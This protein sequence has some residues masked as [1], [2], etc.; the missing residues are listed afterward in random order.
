MAHMSH[1]WQDYLPF[2][3]VGILLIIMILGFSGVFTTPVV[4][5]EDAECNLPVAVCGFGNAIGF[6]DAWLRTDTFLWYCFIP[7]A[8]VWMIVY[9]FLERIRIF[10]TSIS[11]VL[12]FL[13]A[14]SMV[15]LG[16]FVLI[17][18]ILFS[19]IGIYSI[20]LFFALFIIGTLMYSRGLFR[21]WKDLYK[22]YDTAIDRC[23][24]PIKEAEKQI[25]DLNIEIDRANRKVGKKYKGLTGAAFTREVT[26]LIRQRDHWIKRR[27][28]WVV[29]KQN[30]EQQKKDQARMFRAEEKA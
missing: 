28:E 29:R 13:I 18:S 30:L 23:D 1:R 19:F 20:I 26:E 11:G 5:P 14:F 24:G 16:I 6:P 17:V 2:A 27:E 15:P 8:G 7:M 12:A 9:G 4:M 22:S 3:L 21:S 25:N 10:K